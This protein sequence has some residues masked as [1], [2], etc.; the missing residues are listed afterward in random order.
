MK[1]IITLFII[2][3][4][5]ASSFAQAPQKMSYQAVIRNTS[6]ALVTSTSVG[7]KISILQGSATGTVAYSETQTASTNANGLVSLEIGSGTIVTGT[8]AGINWANGPYFIKTE[9][10]PTGGTAYTISG[11]NELM[12]VPYALFSANGPQGPVGPQGSPGL[13]GPAGP[14][15]PTGAAGP[16]GTPGLTGPA[17]V[18][19]P[20]GL[21]GPAGPTGAAGPQGTPGLTG[22]AGVTGPI[23]LTGPAGAQGPVGPAPAPTNMSYAQNVGPQLYLN[24]GNFQNIVSVSLTTTGGPVLVSAYGDANVLGSSVIGKL[25]LYR[26]T[27]PLGNYC[28]I[29]GNGS[30]ENQQYG[31]SV[32]DSV[33]LAGSY[34]YTLKAVYLASGTWFG[35][36]TGPVIH[37]IELKGGIGATGPAGA[38]G[39]QGLNALIKTTLE[40]IGAN[41]TAGGTKFETGLDA[42]GNGILDAGE[43]NAALTTYVCNG[44]GV[45]GGTPHFIGELWGGGIV[46]YVNA[47]GDHGLICALQDQSAGTNFGLADD[48]I[49]NPLNHNLAGQVFT[50]WQIPSRYQLNLMYSTLHLASP[51]LGGFSPSNY[52]SSSC[53]DNSLPIPGYV[54]NFSTGVI[55]TISRSNTGQKV[56]AIRTF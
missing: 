3:F 10:D 52:W 39:S 41:C 54:V 29:E 11:T 19:G 4:L 46:F 56:R 45:G 6:G 20:I 8:F 44:V 51:P 53:V 55:S 18:T 40:P 37:A 7:M 22:P 30:N 27:I 36:T 48:A 42:N 1:N 26:D 17:G 15:G 28:W 38:N 16:Q 21:T 14:T 49:S 13:T 47:S 23:G 5:A 9:T 50:D 33:P 2:L 25:Q 32:I 35:E 34:N 31:L 24:S 12:S 43:I